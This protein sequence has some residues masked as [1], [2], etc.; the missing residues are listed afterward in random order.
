MT[1]LARATARLRKRLQ[2]VA[3]SRCQKT[4]DVRKRSQ[5]MP[6][7]GRK[8]TGMVRQLIGQL[9]KRRRQCRRRKCGTSGSPL[10]LPPSFWQSP[11]ALGL[12]RSDPALARSASSAVTPRRAPGPRPRSG[13]AGTSDAHD[14]MQSRRLRCN[15]MACG[16]CNSLYCSHN[17]PTHGSMT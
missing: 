9:Q 1:H 14:A 16:R 7:K 15:R 17:A 8:V 2:K 6:C 13:P 12:R 3:V 10:P 5:Q 11:G 4:P